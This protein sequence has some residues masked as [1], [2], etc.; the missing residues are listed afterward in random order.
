MVYILA[1]L[2]SACLISGQASWGS[3][4]KQ[5]APL[6]SNV[7]AVDLLTKMIL[8]PRFWLGV[9][10]Y[11]VGTGLYFLLL[12]K[13]RFFSVQITMT[14]LAVVLSVLIAHFF[15]KES[16]SPLN[17]VGVSLVVSGIFLVFK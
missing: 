15:F 4:V 17:L 1:L 7:G 6:G 8:S 3:A 12:S 11:L 5:I 16:I 13:V 9:C 2:I 14:G 10:F